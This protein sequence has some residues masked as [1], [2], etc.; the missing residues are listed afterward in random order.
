MEIEFVDNEI[1]SFGG[2][3]ILKQLL[4]NSGFIKELENLPLPVQGSNRGYPPIQLFVQFMA[5]IWC[6]AN[7]FSHL[8]VTRFDT[9]IQ[10]IFEIGRASCRER[11]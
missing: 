2:L 9:S 6:G 3:V 4:T 11:V 7:R 8:D 1:T 5:S 10:R